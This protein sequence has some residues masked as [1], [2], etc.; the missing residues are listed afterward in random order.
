[1]DKSILDTIHGSAKDLH[2]AGVMDDVT[3]REFDALS[4][5][6]VKA[7]TPVQVARFEK[8]QDTQD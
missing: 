3:M 7:Y 2:K 8:K 5:P 6:P 1:M 4:L